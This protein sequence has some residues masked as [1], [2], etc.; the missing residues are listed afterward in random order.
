MENTG[1]TRLET[2]QVLY[3]IWGYDQTNIDFYEVVKG[4]EEGRFVELREL[5][6]VDTGGSGRG[7]MASTKMPV[8]VGD[9][10]FA[11]VYNGDKAILRRKL[12]GFQGKPSV[13]LA[14]YAYAYPWDGTAK[15]YSWDH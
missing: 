15:H 3:S 14:S 1:K 7:S 8:L 2:G 5:R 10:R 9:D 4:A 11:P 12:R 6:Y 13:R